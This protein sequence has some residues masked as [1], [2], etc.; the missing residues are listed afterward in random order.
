MAILLLLAVLVGALLAF[1]L[2]H[3]HKVLPGSSSV[4][5]TYTSPIVSP[6]TTTKKNVGGSTDVG[7]FRVTLPKNSSNVT[8]SDS[9]ETHEISFS[10]GLISGSASSNPATPGQP[11]AA[12]ASLYGVP[13]KHVA[14]NVAGRRGYTFVSVSGGRFSVVV[15][16]RAGGQYLTVHLTGPARQLS[17]GKAL[18]ATIAASLASE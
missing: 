11:L 2:S 1:S 10:K 15:I 17:R 4:P 9:G 7:T 16:G 6:T 13:S 8:R 14:K 12:F 5:L 3:G 18:A